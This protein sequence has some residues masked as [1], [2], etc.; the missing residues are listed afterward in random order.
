M[1]FAPLEMSCGI[2]SVFCARDGLLL[3]VSTNGDFNGQVPI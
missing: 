2:V 1:C 3:A